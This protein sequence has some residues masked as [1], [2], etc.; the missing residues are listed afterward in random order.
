[1]LSS[2][3]VPSNRGECG[4]WRHQGTIQSIRC[5][6]IG[7]LGCESNSSPGWDQSIVSALE[8]LVAHAPN[9]QSLRLRGIPH[10]HKEQI[11]NFWKTQV[12]GIGD[13]IV[14]GEDGLLYRNSYCHG[15]CLRE[16]HLLPELDFIDQK[17]DDGE[18]IE[19][20]ME[21]ER[22]LDEIGLGRPLVTEEKEETVQ[23]VARLRNPDLKFPSISGRSNTTMT[24]N[25]YQ[26]NQMKP[27]VQ[28]MAGQGKRRTIKSTY[29]KGK[30]PGGSLYKGGDKNDELEVQS[31][32]IL[33]HSGTK[34]EIFLYIYWHHEMVS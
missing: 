9:L 6:S 27:K 26:K 7:P 31:I 1:M 17:H 21:E 19:Y 25:T 18:V 8:K 2:H 30:K 5:L 4:T 20:E 15:T 22:E 33:S 10:S 11:C 29:D 14:S 13:H 32:G 23:L 12:E 24:S 28:H 16:D 34:H 3:G